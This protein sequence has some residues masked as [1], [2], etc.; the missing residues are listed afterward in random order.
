MQKN[1]KQIELV[2]TVCLCFIFVAVLLNSMNAVKKKMNSTQVPVMPAIV[3]L[4]ATPVITNQPAADKEN[5]DW[6][7]DPFSGKIYSGE[8]SGAKLKLS[9]ILWDAKNPQVIIDG[10]MMKV[11]DTIGKYR[12]IK[13]EQNKVIVN[14]GVQDK[15]LPLE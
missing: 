12:I 2:V 14:D 6:R 9:G 7:R 5:L 11:G 1:K 8:S 4:S 10:D 13:I 15:E 3:P